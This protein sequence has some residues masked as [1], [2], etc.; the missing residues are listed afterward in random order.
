MTTINIKYHLVP[1]SNHRANNLEREIETFRNQFIA[2]MCSIDK[3]FHLKLWDRLLQQATISLNVISKS[4]SLPHISAYT[5]IFGEFGFN[6]TP[7]APP[8]TIVVM[9]NRPKYCASWAPH[10]ENGWYVG[11]AME[12]YR[13]HK[14][15][16]PKTR[17][18]RISDTVQ[19]PP[20]HFICHRY[21]PWMQLMIPHKI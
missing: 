10:G 5:Y 3:Y 15:Y 2:G 7:L 1:P 13:C 17:A 18:E 11:P 12:H 8:G 14:A 16:I 6:C 20:K 21:L 9:H 19:F 4:R